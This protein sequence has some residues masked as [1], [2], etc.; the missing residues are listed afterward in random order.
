VLNWARFPS[1]PEQL[2]GGGPLGGVCG[3]ALLVAGGANFPEKMPWDGGKKVWGDTVWLLERPDGA[4]REV[5]RLPRR[6]AYGLSV[7]VK[8]ELVCIGGSDAERHYSD[9]FAL[10][11]SQGK[12]SR[13]P[14]PSLPIPLSAS[15]GACVGNLVYLAC[16]AEQPGEKVATNRA[17]RLDLDAPSPSWE[18]LPA[19]PGKE[20]ILAAGAS[21]GDAFYVFGGAALEANASGAISREYLRD[22]WSYRPEIGWK[23]IA[24]LPKPSVA[25]PSPAPVVDG[26]ILLIAGDDGS[27]VGF[28]PVDQHPGFPAKIFAYDP[29]LDQWSE[30]G[31]TPAPRATVPT[32]EWNGAVLI[33][34]G[35]VRPGVRSPEVW[36]IKRA[37]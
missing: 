15:A 19:L 35:E 25:A 34:S 2:G 32:V 26:R 8:D 31:E 9:V 21:L 5:G 4:W 7:S 14:L 23:R 18:A 11:W 33:P 20:R 36:S 28:Q 10:T 22:A 13:R 30:A 27:R 24:D 29:G 6:L 1:L 37:R 16:G 3:A 12:L 17:F